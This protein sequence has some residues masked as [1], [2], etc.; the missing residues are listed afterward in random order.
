MK[1]LGR[2]LV[3][4]LV[5]AL[6]AFARLLS[7]RAARRLGRAIGS[8]MWALSR[9]DRRR[10][11][12]NLALAYGPGMPPEER[13]RIGRA[14]FANLAG[15]MTELF[16]IARRGP[17]G[18]LSH[19]GES[20]DLGALGEAAASGRGLVLYTAHLNNWELLGAY[21]A[22]RGVRLKV[23]ARRLNDE[24]FDR[25]ITDWRGRMGVETV[26]QDAG[27]RPL[28]EHIRSGGA[29]GVLPDQDVPRLAGEFVEFFGR[30]A[31]TPTGP[32]ALAV[33]E[34][35][36]MV[37]VFLVRRGDSH[38]LVV[39]EPIF[40]PQEGSKRDKVLELTR[41]ATAEIERIVRENPEQWVWMHR[42]W[43]TKRTDDLRA[44]EGADSQ[45]RS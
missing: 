34:G 42:R 35:V 31:W 12:E 36:P 45:G 22:A 39:S 17:A 2:W 6:G 14:C 33:T 18:V 43:R 27:A 23:V 20:Q 1:A 10:A 8:L 21:L 4:L 9:R 13:A 16:S 38:A 19:V 3:W 26:Y 40:A 37:G 15:S 25:M 44:A 5:K 11:L 24:R 30:E 28:L 29:L 7:P 41:R 32:A